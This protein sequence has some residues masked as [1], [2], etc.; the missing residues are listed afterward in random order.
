MTQIKYYILGGFNTLSCISIP[1]NGIGISFLYPLKLSP[2]YHGYFDVM[3]CF[4]EFYLN[5]EKADIK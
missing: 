5:R 3:V 4:Y 1:I 2:G